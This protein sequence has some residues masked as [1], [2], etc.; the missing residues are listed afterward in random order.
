MRDWNNDG[1][2]DGK[3]Y[4]M[5]QYIFEETSKEEGNTYYSGAGH[6]NGGVVLK[7]T[8]IVII[9]ILLLALV[10]G[11]AVPGAVWG[12]FGKVILV[13]GF[14]TLLGKIFS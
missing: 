6:S 5:D 10:L 4:I 11:V 8:V 3:D 12:F 13:V 7:G 14:F 2:I 1:K 9:V